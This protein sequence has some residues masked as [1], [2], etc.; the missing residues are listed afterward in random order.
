MTPQAITK[1]PVLRQIRRL[2]AGDPHLR[3][4]PPEFTG[5][6]SDT[7]CDVLVIGAGLGG[8]TAAA[9]CAR[10]GLSVR[11]VEQHSVVGGFAHTWL[12]RARDPQTGQRLLF[13]FDSGVHDISGTQPGG[14]VAEVLARLGVA[15]RLHWIPTRRR[16]T[17][18]GRTLDMPRRWPDYVAMLQQLFPGEHVAITGFCAAVRTLHAAMYQTGDQSGAIPGQPR[19]ATEMAQFAAD[20]P[21][22]AQW[23]RRPWLEFL[24]RHG[25]SEA[26]S[27]WVN[28]LAGYVTDQAETQSVARM[29]P[30]FGYYMHG[31]AYPRGG[32]G[33][34]SAALR[35]ALQH[36]GGEVLLKNTVTG[37]AVR[38][39]A[40]AEVSIRSGQGQV[41]G[42]TARAVIANSDIGPL[43]TQL[44]NDP[45]RD[46]APLRRAAVLQP[47]CSAFGLC[48]GLRGALDIPPILTHQS[49]QGS[50]HLVAPSVLDSSAAPPGYATLELMTL[51]S[52]AQAA[53]WFPTGREDQRFA[54]YRKSDA[55]RDTK[56]AQARH[57][58]DIA[59]DVIPDLD[60]RIV[61]HCS[62]S[63]LTYH[64]YAATPGG[65]IYGGSLAGSVL[66]TMLPVRGL[67][68]AG[69][70]THGPGVEAAMIS[71]ARAAQALVPDVLGAG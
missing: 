66:P 56:A 18:A 45:T 2:A 7:A 55:Y 37:V 68:L 43:L 67:V 52:A 71:G 49:A 50:L 36:A 26:A 34:V 58:L 44:I 62:S 13:R 38:E 46:W 28:E 27:H 8:L 25:L 10:A 20:H 60:D 69:S 59:R 11:V 5:Q 21:L 22:A 16:C 63:P 47:S 14:P 42:I 64:R 54:E 17:I 61:F 39:D 1:A 31:G 70:A 65:A 19:S 12:R 40:P 24:T 51:V 33:A 6:K 57:L 29:I 32:S 48:L 30:L 35:D 9:F 41:Q 23:L 3:W 53:G 15:D 4:D